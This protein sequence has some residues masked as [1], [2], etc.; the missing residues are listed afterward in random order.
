MKFLKILKDYK[1][2]IEDNILY[3]M[4][5]LFYQSNANDLEKHVYALQ[6]LQ[7]FSYSET[8]AAD[9]STLAYTIGLKYSIQSEEIG[10]AVAN[11]SNVNVHDSEL[12]KIADVIYQSDTLDGT[13]GIVSEDTIRCFILHEYD[14]SYEPASKI[15]VLINRYLQL[16]FLLQYRYIFMNNKMKIYNNINDLAYNSGDKHLMDQVRELYDYVLLWR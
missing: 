5:E 2:T 14:D 15:D 11:I 4:V 8:M 9:V 1:S 3:T 16:F 6:V 13:L 7:R 12:R 10:D